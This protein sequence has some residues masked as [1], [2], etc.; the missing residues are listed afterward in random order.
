MIRIPTSR[1]PTHPGKMLIEEFL[2]P[3]DIS[4]DALADA[5]GLPHQ[6]ITDIIEKRQHITEDIAVELGKFFNMSTQFWLNLQM[7]WDLYWEKTRYVRSI[8]NG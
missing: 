2:E 4:S 5:T 3:L 1:E 8:A 7:C 6:L